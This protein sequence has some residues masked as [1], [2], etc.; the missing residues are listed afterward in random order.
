MSTP[1]AVSNAAG[2]PSF[3]GCVLMG[4]VPIEQREVVFTKTCTV[5]SRPAGAVAGFA[6]PREP[7]ADDPDSVR[8][9]IAA[10]LFMQKPRSRQGTEDFK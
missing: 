9:I 4:D 6:K 10:Q 3:G 5:G 2:P 7:A 1:P 8:I